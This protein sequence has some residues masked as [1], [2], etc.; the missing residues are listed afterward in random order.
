MLETGFKVV[1]VGLPTAAH[2]KEY[3]PKEPYLGAVELTIIKTA[4]M[5]KGL[6]RKQEC[7]DVWSPF[8]A[9]FI[10]YLIENLKS[11]GFMWNTT[12]VCKVAFEK[13]MGAGNVLEIKVQAPEMTEIDFTQKKT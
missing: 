1:S 13:R 7:A 12:Q 4:P 9:D 11:A 5:K 2:L 6:S 8:D 10:K 3:A